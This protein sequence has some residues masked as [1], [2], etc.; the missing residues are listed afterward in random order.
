MS[1]T[2]LYCFVRSVGRQKNEHSPVKRHNRAVV[3]LA[4]GRQYDRGVM[5]RLPPSV[6]VASAAM[7]D[8]CIAD[9]RLASRLEM[10]RANLCK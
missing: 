6:I 8:I 5:R 9:A 10:R 1:D 7:L 4:A 2:S 3:F